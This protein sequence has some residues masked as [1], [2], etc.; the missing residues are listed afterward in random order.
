MNYYDKMESENATIVVE[1]IKYTMKEWKKIKAK[2]AKEEAI[3]ERNKK[4]EPL[5]PQF[6]K[7]MVGEFSLA[8]SLVAYYNNGYRQWGNVVKEILAM[9]NVE[10]NFVLLKKHYSEALKALNAIKNARSNTRNYSAM[11]DTL[12]YRL[13]DCRTDVDN[14]SNAIVDSNVLTNPFYANKE[15]IFGEGRRLGLRT[16]IS[17][18]MLALND[19]HVAISMIRIASDCGTI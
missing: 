9:P 5:L 13:D 8:K 14:L 11:L 4:I 3:V 6:C 15:C 18:T 1:G 7:D 17:R 16:L 19:M 10:H 12:W 2:K